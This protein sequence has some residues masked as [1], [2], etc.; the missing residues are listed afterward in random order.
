MLAQSVGGSVIRLPAP[1]RSTR[2]QLRA[3]VVAML[4]IIR[5]HA[6]AERGGNRHASSS[7][8]AVYATAATGRVVGM[9]AQH[10]ESA[11]PREPAKGRDASCFPV[12]RKRPLSTPDN[13]RPQ[14]GRRDSNPQPLDR[15]SNQQ[16]FQD[17]SSEEVS[18]HDCAACTTACTNCLN[19][20]SIDLAQLAAILSSLSSSQRETLVRLMIATP[21]PSG[22]APDTAYPSSAGE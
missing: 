1:P 3:R 5:S 14:R 15:Q 10:G 7:S 9:L 21:P 12:N 2:P 11:A 8:P 4:A 20:D 19:V 6:R 18:D 22:P 13:E 17:V 16:E